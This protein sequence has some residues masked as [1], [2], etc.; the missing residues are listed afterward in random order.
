[1]PIADYQN[2][3]N[4][5]LRRLDF[6]DL[7]LP[8]P[9][10]FP[11]SPEYFRMR[12]EFRIWHERG[13][14][15]YAMHQ[16]GRKQPYPL[17]VDSKERT[18]PIASIR[19]NQLM[20]RLLAR[21]NAS[22]ILRERLFSVEFLTSLSGEAVTTLIYHR[23]LDDQWQVEAEQLREDLDTFIIGRSR[24]QKLVV[25]QDFITETLT[26]NGRQ[27]HYQQIESGFTQPNAEINQHMLGWAQQYTEK[28]T[29]DLLELYCG[30]GNFTCVLAQNFRR[31]LATEVAKISVRSALHNLAL[32][33][34]D[35]VELVRMSSEELGQALN[36][37]RPFRRLQGIDLDNYRFS[38]VLVDPPRAGLDADTLQLVANIE[39]ILYISC[40]PL[41]LKA[42]L[43]TLGL[44]H[45]IEQFAV[46]DQFPYTPHL[47]CAVLLQRK[48]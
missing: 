29:G 19:I 42:N 41:T 37:V 14:A 7:N 44:T 38:T 20:P 35:N 4:E 43:I 26:V 34:I 22:E 16:P 33:G 24:K 6:Q 3:L 21:I 45:A 10:I 18:F 5:K 23:K 39:R 9:E 1:M 48:A 36:K 8:K 40:N 27:Y 31:V 28:S 11:S 25:G 47:E 32:N 15:Y 17:P 12:A 30:N 46:F 13:V 2:Q